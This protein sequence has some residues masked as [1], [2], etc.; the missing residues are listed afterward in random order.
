M[1]SIKQVEVLVAG[2]TSVVVHHGY[3]LLGSV[4]IW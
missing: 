3:G 2:Y 4:F 1:S